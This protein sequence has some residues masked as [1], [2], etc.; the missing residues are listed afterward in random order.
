MATHSS[1]MAM[2]GVAEQFSALRQYLSQVLSVFALWRLVKRFWAWIRGAKNPTISTAE[3]ERTAFSY[4][5]LVMF[6]ALV[7]GVPILVSRM[8]RDPADQ[9][10]DNAKQVKAADLEFARVLYDFNGDGNVEL[11]LKKGD[12]VAVLSRNS[13]DWWQGRT[14]DGRTGIFPQNYV[15]IIP[16]KEQME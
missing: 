7:L 4:K 8:R 6:L 1:F 13:P 11:V 2:V 16:K 5:P 3:F 12:L 14:R 15:Q 9:A 10:W